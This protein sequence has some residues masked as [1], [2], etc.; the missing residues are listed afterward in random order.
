MFWTDSCLDWCISISTSFFAVFLSGNLWNMCP[1]ISILLIY[2]AQYQEFLTVSNQ[3][4]WA[5]NLWQNKQDAC[6]CA[7]GGRCKKDE[8]VVRKSLYKNSSSQ[9]IINRQRKAFVQTI[10]FLPA[11]SKSQR[12]RNERLVFYSVSCLNDV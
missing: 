6:T 1:Q 3:Y 11:G 8:R 4:Q 5:E 10:K 7:T 12:N 9:R 2:A